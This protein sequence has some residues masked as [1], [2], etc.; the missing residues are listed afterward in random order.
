MIVDD[1][2][3][4]PLSFATIA[5]KNKGKGTVSNNNGNFGMKIT[6]DFSDDTLI[7]LLSWIFRKRNPY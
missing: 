4:E 2:T 7:F 1:E 6:P 5:L 3:S